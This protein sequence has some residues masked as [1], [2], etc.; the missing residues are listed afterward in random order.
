MNERTDSHGR[1]TVEAAHDFAAAAEAVVADLEERLPEGM[2]ALERAMAARVR[3]ALARLLACAEQ[4][5]NEE[6]M[7]R[8]STG[9]RRQH[10]L[11]KAE[12][13]LRREID[14]ALGELT[15]RAENH[16]VVNRLNNA[17]RL[18]REAAAAAQAAAAHEPNAG[19]VSGET[20]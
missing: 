18:R 8:G 14:K 3:L 9:Q 19:R 16:A 13:D 11:L 20:P 4:L 15:F 2:E 5:A 1:A 7:I 12:Q 6:L 10:P 17:A